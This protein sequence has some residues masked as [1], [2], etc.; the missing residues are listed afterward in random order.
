MGTLGD[1]IHELR[2]KKRMTLEELAKKAVLTASFLSQLER[3]IVYPSI[4]SLKKIASILRVPMGYFFREE[5]PIPGMLVKKGKR[6]RFAGD[7]PRTKVE[8]LSYST[9]GIK[10]EPLIFNLEPGGQ[11][12][13]QLSPHEGEEFGFVL[14]GKIQLSVGRNKYLMDEGD[15][16]CFSSMQSHSFKNTGKCK[17]TVLWVIFSPRGIM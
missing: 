4:A 14:K 11:T 16:I 7:D 1:K 6:K 8:V 12:G 17:A 2:I 13:S 3:S 9:L 10:M 5:E 15:S